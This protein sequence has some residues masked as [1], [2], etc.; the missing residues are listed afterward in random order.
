MDSVARQ[1]L[2]D[3]AEDVQSM[4]GMSDDYIDLL[5]EMWDTTMES[6]TT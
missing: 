6:K 5:T 2:I 4:D 1:A 3:A